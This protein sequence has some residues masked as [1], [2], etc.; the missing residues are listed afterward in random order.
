VHRWLLAADV[1]CLTSNNE[2]FP[3]VV[4]EAMAAGLPVVCTSFTSAREI[5]PDA[6]L[7]ILTPVGDD[8]E[9]ARQISLLLDDQGRRMELGRSARQW[10]GD[11]F[12]WSKLV[13][14]MESLYEELVA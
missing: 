1:F 10:V 3:N 9:M 2:G 4:L 5:I 11:R 12:G 6:S 14:Q 13:S 8:L 7:G